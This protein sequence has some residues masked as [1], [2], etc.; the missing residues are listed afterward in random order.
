MEFR[1][2]GPLE[3]VID[4]RRAALSGDKQ[5]AVLALLVIHAN[6]TLSPERL[7]DELWGE[8]PPA[9]A[10]KTLQV[11][12]SRLRKGL[13]QAG[14]GSGDGV[15][16]TRE[17]GYELTVNRER[18][19]SIRFER[20]IG[21][22]RG[23]LKVGRVARAAS[24]L[25]EA[26]SLW[27]GP[28]LSEFC[29]ERFAE[30]EMARLGELRLG[31]L[32]ELIEV[33][34]A[35]GRHTEVVGE[36]EAL[37]A[38][39]PYR[40]R[41]RAQLMLALY[42][43]DRQAEA[44]QAYQDARCK[45]V[46]EL[47]IEPGHELRELHQAVLAQDPR[48]DLAAA[49]R[50]LPGPDARP[51]L[52]AAANPLIGRQAE[53]RAVR[54][55]LAGDARLVTV[56][57]AGGSGKTRL[58]L[59]L[60][61]SLADD[62]ARAVCFVALA[63]VRDPQLLPAAI[64]SALGIAESPGSALE[65]IERTLAGQP[66]LLVLDNFEHLT[67][68]APILTELLAA[69]PQLDVLVTSRASLHLSGEHE[70]PLNPLPLADAVALFTERARAVRPDFAADQFVLRAICAR[71][72]CLPLAVELAA[73]RCRLL[74]C[75]E[76]LPRLEHRL[77]L[78]TGGA[79]DLE[80][81]QQTLRATIEWSYELLDPE[82]QRL[83]AR[84]ALFTG[85]CT[86]E[87]AEQVCAA[88]LDQLESLL[89]QNLLRRSDAAGESRFWMLETLREY[90]LERLAL[91]ANLD[92]ACRLCADYYIALARQRIAEHDHG[93]H[94]A[95]DALERDLDNIRTALA[96]THDA[97]SV[98]VPVDDGACDHLDGLSIPRLVL[99]STQG[100]VD[101]AEFAAE[102]LVLYV[103]PGTTAPGQSTL[104][105]LS[106]IPGGLGCTPQA[107]AFRDHA[108]ELAALGARV[109]GLSVVSLHSLL[110]FSEAHH[111]PFP[112]ISDTERRLDAALG[113]PTF[114]VA[115]AT[116]YRRVTLIAERGTIVKIFHPVFPPER[117]ADEV[118][119]WISERT[120]SARPEPR[121]P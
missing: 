1:I 17:H 61:T 112:V 36:V 40:E 49:A 111:I 23:E 100:P 53:L 107:L 119:A 72:D 59:E 90:A 105:G 55:L 33:K 16:V 30:V 44:L 102:R 73:A 27:R 41:L 54:D 4:G 110:Q 12:I 57:G 14:G 88:S 91:T 32:E 116:L 5:R 104:P 35:L 3:V 18:V 26:L 87:A 56:T 106:E 76:L 117:N 6:R 79:R 71:L 78:L 45:L 89:D 94:A 118:V 15:V 109:A 99:D 24:L 25:E 38:E 31:A 66:A 43:S 86:L 101:L 63:P 93:Q 10:A 13:E 37:T 28:P 74:S 19:D 46:E 84:L 39:H 64:I 65:T 52:P 22:A 103:Q 42:R 60:A 70:Y 48:L 51:S 34:L 98:P 81:R 82:E 114:Q 77:E 115:G 113:L 50:P 92:E 68:S 69:C 120:D 67:P 95:L 121:H 9:S 7:I 29:D 62:S 21:E 58:A 85:G 47:G 11:H 2:L 108:A 83:F 80:S 97:D 96:Y 20:L 75:Q 8:H